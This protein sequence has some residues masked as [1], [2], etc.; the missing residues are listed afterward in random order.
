MKD[1]D[2]LEVILNMCLHIFLL[3]F[4]VILFY[5]IRAA[6]MERQ[7]FLSIANKIPGDISDAILKQIVENPAL[8]KAICD[9]SSKDWQ[10]NIADK[11]IDSLNKQ[12]AAEDVERQKHNN[13]FEGLALAVSFLILL[14]GAALYYT[15]A[16]RGNASSIIKW[17]L[18]TF[19]IFTLFEVGFFTF[20]I[21][22]YKS[23]SSNDERNAFM[24][25]ANLDSKLC[26]LPPS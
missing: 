14:C 24:K 18:I 4:F 6:P 17:N 23:F 2:V 7:G 21:S 26:N 16:G 1:K 5:Y 22:K 11:L 8:R 19:F 12:A 25:G 3:S 10:D 20:A 9:I 13:M 15:G